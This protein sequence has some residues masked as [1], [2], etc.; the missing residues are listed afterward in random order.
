MRYLAVLLASFMLISCQSVTS[1]TVTVTGSA[2]VE[3]VPDTVFFDLTASYVGDT[4]DE[5]RSVA[6]GLIG[7]SLTLLESYGVAS[8]D[9]R[10]AYFSISPYYEYSD[11]TRMLVGQSAVESV[12][13]T[14]HDTECLGDV[15]E[16]LSS[17]DGI[18]IS[19]IRLDKTDKSLE[20]I[21]ARELAVQDAYSRA[22]VYATAAGYMLGDLIS[23]SSAES[24]G[25]E[26]ARVYS[27]APESGTSYYP[28]TIEVRDDV[29]AV[30]SLSE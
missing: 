14:L 2:V 13:V 10:T 12:S 6:S 17:M 11:G 27:M 8:D 5:A 19:G 28:G 7:H 9:V 25:L 22:T 30:F 26:E 24:Y 1:P 29:S 21:K 23:I 15:L 16:A 18:E 4:A 20:R 3:A